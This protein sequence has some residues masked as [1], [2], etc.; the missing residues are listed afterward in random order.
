MITITS[1]VF[2]PS[3]VELAFNEF[4]VSVAIAMT[5][6]LVDSAD[7]YPVAYPLSVGSI[8]QQALES[9]NV[10]SLSK[11]FNASIQ[12]D[13]DTRTGNYSDI[14]FNSRQ[15]AAS[16][17]MRVALPTPVAKLANN[18]TVTMQAMFS[19][20]GAEYGLLSSTVNMSNYCLAYV[21]DEEKTWVC[22]FGDFD[23]SLRVPI[24][25]IRPQTATSPALVSAPSNRI[26]MLAFVYRPP[27][28]P[29]VSAQIVLSWWELYWA[30]FLAGAIFLCCLAAVSRHQLVAYR[31]RKEARDKV[32]R[33]TQ[34]QFRRADMLRDEVDHHDEDPIIIEN[35]IKLRANLRMGAQEKRIHQ[36]ELVQR[37]DASDAAAIQMSL[38]DQINQL[39]MDLGIEGLGEE[40]GDTGL[41]L[42]EYG[43]LE[44]NPSSGAAQKNQRSMSWFS[45]K[46]KS[47]ARS[48]EA[49]SLLNELSDD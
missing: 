31:K 22:V 41:L 35:P 21:D 45:K 39:D 44:R 1:S 3:Q 4:G 18:L 34:E 48:A 33:E 29:M 7:L 5:S 27:P 6:G 11:S 32:I 23:S 13:P 43:D 10:T 12:R 26:G 42:P 20:D 36:I 14:R 9:D 25:V 49:E 24:T 28:P 17:I 16:P 2:A 38:L 47:E 37:Q 40:G 8:T 19:T 15:V 30:F 46:K